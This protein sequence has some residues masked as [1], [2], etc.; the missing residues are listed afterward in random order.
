M[1][2]RFDGEYFFL[3]NFYPYPFEFD[4]RRWLT[5]EHAYQAAKANDEQTKDAF[6]GLTAGKAKRLGKKIALRPDWENI[7][8]DVM[9]RI[10]QAKFSHDALRDG[11]LSTGDQELVEGNNWYDDFWGV[12]TPGKGQNHLGKLLMR[13]R[14]EIRLA[15]KI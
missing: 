10:L 3:S 4:G 15:G 6:I 9:Y 14:S 13:V 5:S 11:L 8:L 2:D 7:K 1:I 12:H